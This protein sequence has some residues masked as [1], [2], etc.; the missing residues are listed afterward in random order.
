MVTPRKSHLFAWR[1]FLVLLVFLLCVDSN[2]FMVQTFYLR[3]GIFCSH[4]FPSPPSEFLFRIR[5]EVTSVGFPPA[6][7]RETHIVHPQ[8]NIPLQGFKTKLQFPG[9][10]GSHGSVVGG[11]AAGISLD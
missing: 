3:M 7:H 6:T 5:S 11:D 2:V 8:F 10:H 1:I 4:P 9:S